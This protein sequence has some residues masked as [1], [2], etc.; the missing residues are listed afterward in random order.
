[1]A[2]IAHMA[3]ESGTGVRRIAGDKR[4]QAH[5]PQDVRHDL[6]RRRPGT[7]TWA[8]GALITTVAR[9]PSPQQRIF[10][11]GTATAGGGWRSAT[12]WVSPWYPV[13][14]Q[15][16]SRFVTAGCLTAG[17]SASAVAGGSD[18]A[19]FRDLVGCADLV[20]RTSI[21]IAETTPGSA[22]DV[23]GSLT[24]GFRSETV[25]GSATGVSG[26][27]GSDGSGADGSGADGS[28]ADVLAGCIRLR[29]VYL[30]RRIRRVL[31]WLASGRRSAT[32]WATN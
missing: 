20:A 2:S 14:R 26:A 19:D 7:S 15:Q 27:D 18:L 6:G 22:T 23:S 9:P 28:G 25:S 3:G 31:G 10:A 4:V 11:T 32:N 12:V 24:C 1:M 8:A 5:S 17:G 16:H 13:E 29:I 30:I 21:S